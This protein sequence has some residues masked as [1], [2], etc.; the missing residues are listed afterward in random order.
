MERG[1]KISIS[2]T[3]V[4]KYDTEFHK[5]ILSERSQSISLVVQITIQ[6]RGPHPKLL[7]ELDWM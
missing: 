6:G 3:N 7:S 4:F 5:E 1:E 2:H